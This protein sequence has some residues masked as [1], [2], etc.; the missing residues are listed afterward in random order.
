MRIR[1]SFV[2][3]VSR[4]AMAFDQRVA[5]GALEVFAHHLG[6]QLLECHLRLPA[7]FFSGFGG[8][9]EQLLHL[10]RAEIARVNADDSL[11]RTECWGLR[12]EGGG[13]RAESRGLSPE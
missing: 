8:I 2:V 5:L 12:T 4:V 6:D 11:T 7:K 1:A 3:V 13:L 9:A 10:G